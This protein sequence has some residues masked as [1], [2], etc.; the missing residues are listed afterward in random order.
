MSK[1]QIFKKVNKLE[2]SEKTQVKK[3]T[4]KKSKKRFWLLIDLGILFIFLSFLFYRP[5]NYRTPTPVQTGRISTYW[6]QKTSEIYNKAQMRE[7]FSIEFSQ[8]GI[9]EAVLAGDW[10][11]ESAGMSFSAPQV[12]FKPGKIVLIGTASLQDIEL[13]VTVAGRPVINEAGLINLNVTEFKVGAIN[14]I[15]IAKIIAQNSFS[16]ELQKGE[17]DTSDIRAKIVASIINDEPFEVVFTV[18]DKK[19]KITGAQVLGE[20]IRIDF[21]PVFD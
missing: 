13:V 14:V 21:A 17:I 3:D 4:K 19:I 7:S 10:P 18:E 12:L 2:D 11:K 15:L 20:K 6:K 5:W 16:K 9:S 8:E 1:E